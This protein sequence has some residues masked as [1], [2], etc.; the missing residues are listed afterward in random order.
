[1]IYCYLVLFRL[2]A[3]NI[4]RTGKGTIWH[5]IDIEIMYKSH[6]TVIRF[7]LYCS[8]AYWCWYFWRL[9]LIGLLKNTTGEII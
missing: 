5:L 7:Q 2:L 1:M 3:G 8:F 6:F 9:M 4:Y